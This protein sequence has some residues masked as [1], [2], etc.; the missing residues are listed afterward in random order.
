MTLDDH[1]FVARSAVLS[2]LSP[3][4]RRWHRFLRQQPLVPEALPQPVVQPGARDFVLCGASRTGTTLLAAM[5]FQPPHIVTVMEPWDGMRVPPGDLFASIR[6]HIA[7]A[8]ELRHGKLDVEALSSGA[9]RW[10]A[11]GDNAVP[12]EVEEDFSLGVKWPIYWRFLPYLPDTKFLVTLR[13]P[14]E[15]VASCQR[16]SG[17]L[18][19][20]LNYDMPFNDA[21]NRALKQSTRDIA[22]R[23]IKLYDYVYERVLPF[24]E[25]DNV[26]PVRYERWFTEPE[27]LRQE[28]GAFLGVPVG[29]GLPKI[30]E[31]RSDVLSLE[32]RKLVQMHCTTAAALGYTLD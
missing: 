5:L 3:G 23:R 21:M 24:L 16:M 9:V 29:P 15:V 18:R 25:R 4:R 6:R 1:L 8:G 27:R 31:P 26:L 30:R 10:T 28:I 7:R 11:E 32:D 19:L 2:L 20:G 14:Y 17:Q 12:L 13:H 22:V